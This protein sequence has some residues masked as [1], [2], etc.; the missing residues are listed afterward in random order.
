MKCNVRTSKY[1]GSINIQ[2]H[3]YSDGCFSADG[4][5]RAE[6]GV[7]GVRWFSDKHLRQY[8][9]LDIVIEGEVCSAELRRK[10]PFT[11][12][13][14]IVLARRFAGGRL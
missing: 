2:K 10:R 5:V 4:F 8:L 14:I 6:E 7:V 3:V 9:L 1:L 13:G 12:R 11:E